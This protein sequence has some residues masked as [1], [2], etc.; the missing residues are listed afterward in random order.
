MFVYIEVYRPT[1]NNFKSCR[2]GATASGINQYCRELICLAQGRNTMPTVGIEP[3][4]PRFG[5]RYSTTASPRSLG[6]VNLGCFY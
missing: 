4:A 3:K 1:L 5:V 2:D 6:T